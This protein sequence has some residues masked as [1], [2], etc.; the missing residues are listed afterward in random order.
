[1]LLEDGA[2]LTLQ[3]CILR[4]TILTR[5]GACNDHPACVGANRP[6]VQVYGG[7][8]LL[9]GTDLPST[10]MCAP[11]AVFSCDDSA[12]V[13]V[14]GFACADEV[15]VKGHSCVRG[16]VV[17]DSAETIDPSVKRPGHGRGYESYPDAIE[18]GIE[19][20]TNVVFPNDT[21]PDPTLDVMANCQ[22]GNP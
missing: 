16:M 20:L 12:R 4:G 7:L 11:D 13:E 5:H 17:T 6:K 15:T 14:N 1:M 22:V 2:T 8:R 10:A 3:D 19:E 21:I 9:A 18:P